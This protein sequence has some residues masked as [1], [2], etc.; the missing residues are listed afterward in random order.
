MAA[1]AGESSD[2]NAP[3]TDAQW[4]FIRVS[5]GVIGGA[6]LSLVFR[7]WARAGVVRQFG[8]DDYAVVAAW[9]MSVGF[10]VCSIQW[11]QCGFGDHLWNVSVA[12]LAKYEEWTIPVITTYCWAPM[13]LKFSLLMLYHQLSPSKPFRLAIYALMAVVVGYSVASTVVVGAVCRPTDITKTQC[14]NNLTLIQAVVNIVTDGLV[15]LLPLPMIYRLRLPGGQRMIVGLALAGGCFVIAASILRIIGIQKLQEVQDYT[16]EQAGISIWSY[17]TPA[18]HDWKCT[19]RNVFSSVEINVGI[20]CVNI[21]ALKPFVKQ[22]FPFMLADGDDMYP[23]TNTTR[24]RSRI[25]LPFDML[26]RGTTGVTGGFANGRFSRGWFRGSRKDEIIVTNTYEVQSTYELR[27]GNTESME[28]I[29]MG[30]R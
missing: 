27:I 29:I 10:F 19:D 3:V 6:T 7:I 14:I 12:M 11:M 24:S 16:W 4:D 22:Y 17:V 20:I 1:P 5:A 13:L 18:P 21:V 9:L 2:F 15:L 25:S 30:K 23:K 8:L 28:N 26:T